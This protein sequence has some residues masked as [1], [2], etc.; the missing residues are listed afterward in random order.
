MSARRC[1]VKPGDLSIIVD[2]YVEY[3]DIIQ[4]NIATSPWITYHR[5]TLQKI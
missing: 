5:R 1:S 2:V 4:G 3:K